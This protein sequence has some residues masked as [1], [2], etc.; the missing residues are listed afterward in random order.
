M[1]Y[2]T[3]RLPQMRARTHVSTHARE[4]AHTHTHTHT[5]TS[6]HYRRHLVLDWSN[7]SFLSIVDGVWDPA[8]PLWGIESVITVG[9]RGRYSESRHLL[10]HFFT[11]L[12]QGRMPSISRDQGKD[13]GGPGSERQLTMSPK[14]FM[15][16][17]YV[18]TPREAS[19][20]WAEICFR[21]FSQIKRRE[22]SST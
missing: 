5:H 22:I 14:W 18:W 1:S 9:S 12:R 7:V 4:H 2:T 19:R 15:A 16:S 20:L 17:S 10:N 11:G 3:V 6:T 8:F 13:S 21:F